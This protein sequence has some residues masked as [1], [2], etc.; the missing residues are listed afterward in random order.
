MSL[1]ELK[2]NVSSDSND[3]L[4]DQDYNQIENQREKQRSQIEPLLNEM[5]TKIEEGKSKYSSQ[6]NSNYFS[7]ENNQNPMQ[8]NNFSNNNISG[9]QLGM[10][11]N[12]I[13]E[14][15]FNNNMN[16]GNNNININNNFN[17]N[18]FNLDDSQSQ[19]S[20]NMNMNK[21]SIHS[22]NMNNNYNITNMN[23]NMNNNSIHS[24]NF[25]MNM[26]N[27]SIHSNKMGINN[28]NINA[29]NMMMN[30]NNNSIHSNKMGM[31]N[32]IDTNNMMMNFY[33]N[34]IHSNNMDMNFTIHNNNTGMENHTN[35]IKDMNMDN[36]NFN[37]NIL[38]EFNDLKEDDNN[39]N[40]NS[41][42]SNTT[43]KIF[44]EK[45]SQINNNML[46]NNDNKEDIY[47][48]GKENE[49]KPNSKL[50]QNLK[51]YAPSIPAN[52]NIGGDKEEF[53]YNSKN[54]K[55]DSL[56]KHSKISSSKKSSKIYEGKNNSKNSKLLDGKK[57]SKNSKLLNDSKGS[58]L[59][60]DM[61]NS[62]NSKVLKPSKNSKLIND[63]NNSK[64]S[65][66]LNLSKNSKLIN[67]MNNSKN[68]KLFSDSN[69]KNSKIIPKRSVNKDDN[70]TKQIL[71]NFDQEKQDTLRK[72]NIIE[73]HSEV[74]SSYYDYTPGEKEGHLN[75][76]LEDINYFG[77]F[78]K[79]EIEKEIKLNPNKFMSPDE[80][81]GTPLSNN[82]KNFFVLG[83]L[84]KVLESQGCSVV[85]ERDEPKDKEKNKEINTTIQF[86]INNMYNFIKY[87][88]HFD[89]GEK[90]NKQ[91][92]E[93]EDKREFFNNKLKKKL[94]K[95]FNL[96]HSDII[97]TN[98]RIGSYQITAIIKKSKFN[99][100][101]GEQ[102]YQ[103]LKK[104]I[105]FDKIIKV[106]KGIL[107]S[108]CKLNPYMLDVRGNNS[109]GGWGINEQRGNHPYYPPKGW[110]GYGLRVLDRFDQGNNNWI[111]YRN[112]EGEWSVA[113][114]GVGSLLGRKNQMINAINDIALNN[115]KTGIRQG[116]KDSNDIYHFGQ[117]VGE[118]VYVTPNPEVLA[119]YSGIFNCNGTNY[120]I[121][122]MTRVKPEKIRCPEE[123]Q[124]YWVINGTDNEVRPYRILIKKVNL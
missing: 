56:I 43:N 62:K 8:I 105:E 94:K 85:I 42:Y 2:I 121:G 16:M 31:N 91:L 67:D 46:S 50:F 124:D 29:N 118:G 14:N 116:F 55:K 18:K 64:N 76:L 52:L 61:N 28:N 95:L 113:Y 74:Y 111:D 48:I 70:Y 60:S 107:L 92:L 33:N 44:K 123:K 82:K 108:G 35:K 69:S 86:L 24:N 98:P 6:N 63:M 77:E 54:Q 49:M 12:N 71:D 88:F 9:S 115:L 80:A 114:H 22:N 93:N 7:N 72:T 39:F 79:Q 34:S 73:R 68:S 122:F 53:D 1:N 109:D 5:K 120:M 102:L 89:Y 101:S 97:M 32:N 26:N 41:N 25:G 100:Y 51:D 83:L 37:N 99:D 20:N 65:K 90:L 3:Q 21:N 38:D 4:D 30:F 40:N 36:Q 87:I 23:M 106:E 96:H 15:N 66:V 104:D 57:M 17:I 75:E 27:N 119:Q 59:I 13:N 58:K 45:M 47:N 110:T 11:M 84:G 103:E 112:V 19:I 81:L 78:S 117:K 10:N